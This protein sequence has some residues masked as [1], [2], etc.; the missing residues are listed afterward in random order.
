MVKT[1]IPS[2]LI[3]ALEY[4]SNE[5]YRFVAGGTDMLIQYHN[6]SLLPIAFKDNIMYI[7]H[8]PELLSVTEDD[9]NIYIG[10]CEPLEA[11]LKNDLVPQLLKDTILEMAS[12]AIRHTGTLGGNVGNA[13]PAGDSLVPMYLLNTLIEVR[14]KHS[15]RRL[16]IQDFIQGVRKIDL[17]PDEIIS[18]I[19]INKLEFTKA[20][21]VKVGPRLSDAI[22]K[23]SFAGAITLV[24]GVVDDLRFAFGAVNITVVR[25]PDIECLYINKSLEE[26]KASIDE[27]IEKYK[28]YIKPIDDQRSNKEYRT[29][30][31]IN[32][33]RGFIEEL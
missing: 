23:V 13:S 33:L 22:S 29:T 21:F 15:T 19:I 3:E 2:S 32:L 7:A 27:I 20:S 1:V 30:V 6:R 4:L 17:H 8:I 12:P 26:L 10:A 11:L 18:R 14:S 5:Q 25:R 31:S 24:N 16:R 9:E 28:P